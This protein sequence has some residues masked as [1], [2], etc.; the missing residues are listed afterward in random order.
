MA[1]LSLALGESWRVLQVQSKTF[2]EEGNNL[3]PAGF[4]ARLSRLPGAASAL[5]HPPLASQACHG[6][7]YDCARRRACHASAEQPSVRVLGLGESPPAGAVLPLATAALAALA[8]PC[9]DL[10]FPGVL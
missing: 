8:S 6:T 5:R 2:N 4:E 1:G 10:L 9:E 3:P 7:V